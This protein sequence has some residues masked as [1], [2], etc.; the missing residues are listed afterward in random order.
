MT[1]DRRLA[2]IAGEQ[3]TP[4]W[5]YDAST[6]RRQIERVRAFDVVRFAQK[7]AS[8]VHLLRLM[9]EQKVLVDA[10]SAGEVARA[11]AAG[12][13]VGEPEEQVVLT[14]DILDRE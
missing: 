9:R 11:L 10:V 4:V 6:I 13:L 1:A 12:Y 7:A 8:N 2:E 3:R 5:V 14:A